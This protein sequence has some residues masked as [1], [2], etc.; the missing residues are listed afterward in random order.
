MGWH[1]DKGGGWSSLRKAIASQERGGKGT[2]V[3]EKG[4]QAY[5][6]TGVGD[7]MRV[8][9]KKELTHTIYSIA[10][11]TRSGLG[12]K[13]L[14]VMGRGGRNRV[15]V[16]LGKGGNPDHSTENEKRGTT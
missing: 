11:C 9:G 6:A 5:S 15:T 8:G 1:S 2:A 13:R 14:G 10:S 4:L 12:E 16:V 3:W 7:L